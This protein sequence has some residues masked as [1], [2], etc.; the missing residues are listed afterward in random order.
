LFVITKIDKWHKTTDYIEL[1]K[2]AEDLIFNAYPEPRESSG[3][4]DSTLS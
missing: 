3:G 1:K 4:S 2:L